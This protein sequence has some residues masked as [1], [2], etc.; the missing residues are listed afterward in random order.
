MSRK[1]LEGSYDT[2]PESGKHG[3]RLNT[4]THAFGTYYI[5]KHFTGTTRYFALYQ[6]FSSRE[7]ARLREAS[8]VHPGSRGL[9][10]VANRGC[11]VHFCSLGF[12]Q[13]RL[14]V[15]WFIRVRVG[16]MG[17]ASGSSCLFGFA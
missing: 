10:L 9:C 15:E 11:P 12:T 5:I 3:E 6:A 13:V 1:I 7:K 16:S 17:R 4:H 14:G 8:R 2:S